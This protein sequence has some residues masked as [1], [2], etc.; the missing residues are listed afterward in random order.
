MKPTVLMHELRQEI[1]LPL[2]DGIPADSSTSLMVSADAL[3]AWGAETEA[4][5]TRELAAM[6]H[7]CR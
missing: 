5:A 3:S 6:L 4:A 7:Q 1:G 2:G